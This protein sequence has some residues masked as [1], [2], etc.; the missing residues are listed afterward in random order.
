MTYETAMRVGVDIITPAVVLFTI[1]YSFRP[2]YTSPIGRAIMAHAVGS[3]MLFSIAFL[4]PW[5]PETYPGYKVVSSVII[6]LWIVG[7]WYMVWA[8]WTTRDEARKAAG[9]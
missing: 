8:L 5:I 2:W 9:S 6:V 3:L 1:G 7:W 4:D